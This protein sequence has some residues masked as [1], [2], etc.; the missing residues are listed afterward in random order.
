[1]GMGDVTF[2][3]ALS[4]LKVC[5]G[6]MMGILFLKNKILNL[7]KKRVQRATRSAAMMSWLDRGS[8]PQEERGGE[9]GRRQGKDCT[10]A[11]FGQPGKFKRWVGVM[12][13]GCGG[14]ARVVQCGWRGS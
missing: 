2:A 13:G 14:P 12:D 7:K 1:M 4:S 11:W 5:Y 3:S 6:G 8:A 9:R 10:D